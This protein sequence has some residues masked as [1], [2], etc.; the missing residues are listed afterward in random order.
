MTTP[1]TG[2]ARVTIASGST[3]PTTPLLDA[4]KLEEAEVATA[5]QEGLNQSLEPVNLKIPPD[6]LNCLGADPSA[7]LGTGSDNALC[8]NFARV[9]KQTEAGCQG[10][11][12]LGA[13]TLPEVPAVL[14]PKD[15]CPAECVGYAE[16]RKQA[17]TFDLTRDLDPRLDDPEDDTIAAFI[18]STANSCS[19][20]DVGCERFTNLEALALGGESEQ[21]F[22]YLRACE[23]PGPDSQTYYTWEGSDTTGY[24]LKTWSLKRDTTLPL[25][26]PP[27]VIV[28]AG[29]DGFIKDP[30]S[31]NQV[32]YIQALDP[33]CRQFYDPEGS[34]FY[35]YES[36]TVLSTDD[37]RQYRKEGSTQADCEKTGGT[38]VPASNQCLYLADQTKSSS[39]D[40]A[41][42]GCRAYL[43]TQGKVQEEVLSEDFTSASLTALPGANTK[44]S[45]S[46]EAVLFGDK[47]LKVEGPADA[48]NNTGRV[49]FPLV[50]VPN[51]L[52][53]LTFW[54]K[55]TDP[56]RPV[57]TAQTTDENIPFGQDELE[58]DWTTFRLG[59]FVATTSTSVTTTQ[60]ML[61]GF[62]KLSFIDKVRISRVQDVTYVIKDS[63]DTPAI[64]DRTP[65]GVPQPQ[66]MLGCQTYVDRNQ[67]Q[68]NARQFTRL[69][70][71]T[72]I[73]C[74]AFVNTRTRIRRGR[75]YGK[76]TLRLKALKTSR[77]VRPKRSRFARPTVTIITLMTN[78]K[79]VRP[80]P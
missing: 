54:A 19:A 1:D 3:A 7:P 76:R 27:K 36:Q 58:V 45:Q 35:R 69:C 6:E 70:K 20:Q 41:N 78:P 33:D 30:L 43:G 48:P 68:V 39:C 79:P 15:L 63:W 57:V 50:A 17:S 31:C 47:S 25:P 5:F 26:Q 4:V 29:A 8:K 66:A 75:P 2:S 60:L 62:P 80:R 64:C 44:I 18:P 32:T 56:S 67:K 59:P 38:F 46:N 14:T 65:E 9:C 51:L 11:R 34:V 49:I 24:Q 21:A 42:T 10:Y 52:Y 77:R 74:T 61:S 73:G 71:D 23:K 53:E 55:T 16:F 13:P 72:A 22:N 28:K 40:I 37:C 12:S